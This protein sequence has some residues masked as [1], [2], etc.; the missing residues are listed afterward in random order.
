[1]P[2]ILGCPEIGDLLELDIDSEILDAWTHR[3]RFAG[4][5]LLIFFAFLVQM[6]L[7][8]HR[9]LCEA[10]QLIARVPAHGQSKGFGTIGT[11]LIRI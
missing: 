4:H 3:A 5:V 1:M 8:V 11:F 2:S 6:E 7:Q 10:S 9:E